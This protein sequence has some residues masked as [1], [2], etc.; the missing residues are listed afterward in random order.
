MKNLK[1][2]LFLIAL[3]NFLAC[4]CLQDDCSGSVPNEM[5][6]KLVDKTTEKPLNVRRF[7]ITLEG[8]PFETA[9]VRSVVDTSLLQSYGSS[10]FKNKGVYDGTIKLDNTVVG[11]Y[12][13]TLT[14]SSCC[15][16]YPERGTIEITQG[17]MT[18][19]RTNVNLGDPVFI[20]LKL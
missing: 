19:K 9:M 18:L 8:F 1:I 17:N 20:T 13:M 14:S 16:P 7:N 15:D 12:R 2:T 6:I 3:S 10:S 4:R 5:N 11:S